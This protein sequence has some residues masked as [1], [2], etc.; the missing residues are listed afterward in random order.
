MYTYILIAIVLVIIGIIIYF[1]MRKSKV[2]NVTTPAAT[3]APTAAESTFGRY[4]Y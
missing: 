4:R 1:L 2:S 3:A